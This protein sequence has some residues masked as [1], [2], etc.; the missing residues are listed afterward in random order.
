MSTIT[1][2]LKTKIEELELD[3]RF[4]E[5]TEATEKVYK[6]AVANVGELAHE[7]RDRVTTLLD[8]AG[9]AIDHRTDGK[10][11][12]TV[13]KVRSQVVHGV[14]KLAARRPAA[15]SEPDVAPDAP[16]DTPTDAPTDPQI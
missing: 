12:E 15:H 11:S 3:R 6:K 10:Y 13:S 14:D 4:D 7:N 5:L 1:E 9:A 2:T 8:K 16:T